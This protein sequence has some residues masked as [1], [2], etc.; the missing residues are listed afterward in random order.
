MFLIHYIPTNRSASALLSVPPNQS[1]NASD[2][3]RMLTHYE[4]TSQPQPSA[5]E[6]GFPNSSV[7]RFLS[8]HR[9]CFGYYLLGYVLMGKAGWYTLFTLDSREVV[10]FDQKASLLPVFSLR[11][12]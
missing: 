7:I 11:Y 10:F 12:H 9:S 4:T 6:S 8:F 3:I 1:E 5:V 2:P